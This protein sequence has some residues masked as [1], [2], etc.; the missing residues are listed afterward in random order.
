[1]ESTSSRAGQG[2]TPGV[3]APGKWGCMLMGLTLGPRPNHPQPFSV[4]RPRWEL[5]SGILLKMEISFPHPF[6]STVQI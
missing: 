3:A 6:P 2:L 5:P 1:M 4:P